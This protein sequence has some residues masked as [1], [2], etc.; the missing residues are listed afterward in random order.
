MAFTLYS[1]FKAALL[2]INALAVLH[3]KRF[4]AKSKLWWVVF[5]ASQFSGR[6]FRN[7]C[8]TRCPL[9]FAVGWTPNPMEQGGTTMKTQFLGLIHAVQ[10]ARGPCVPY[11]V[12]LMRDFRQ[13]DLCLFLVAQSHSSP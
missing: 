7:G 8:P 3:E 9:F 2:M 10:Y 11:K 4:L 13:L 1:L 6:P 12:G 5:A